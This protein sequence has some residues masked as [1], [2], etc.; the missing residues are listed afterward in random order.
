MLGEE[1]PGMSPIGRILTEMHIP[2][3]EYT[4]PGEIRS[5]EQAASERGQRPTQVVRSLLF[6]VGKGS[7]VMVLVA[8][9][10]QVSW[11]L[12]RRYLGQSRLTTA[13]RD[14]VLA[15]TGY[16]VGAV[17]PFGLTSSVDIL[18]DESVLREE[19]VSIG[20]GIRGTTV[21][22]A[23][24]DLLRGLGKFSSLNLTSE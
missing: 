15:I 24:K 11:R 14:E 8:G 16:E 20:S 12:L 23:T 2:H 3:R 13:S 22:V 6:R 17:A 10:A 18:I 9:P 4:H 7:F 21:F 19:E 5:L 1:L